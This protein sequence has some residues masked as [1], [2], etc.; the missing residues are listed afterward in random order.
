[1]EELIKAHSN[2]QWEILTKGDKS[3]AYRDIAHANKK[4]HALGVKA[5]GGGKHPVTMS[6][7]GS[8]EWDFSYHPKHKAAIDHIHSKHILPHLPDNHVHERMEDE[9]DSH[10]TY[11]G[12]PLNKPKLP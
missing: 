5:S 4:L 9:D 1:M 11:G 12:A 2:G 6:N 3:A 7:S 10:I 8:P